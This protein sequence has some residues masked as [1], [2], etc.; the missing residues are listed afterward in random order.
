MVA[1]WLLSI[2]LSR[3][4]VFGGVVCGAVRAGTVLIRWPIFGCV[5]C[6]A[7]KAGTVL[8][9]WSVFGCVVCSAVWAGIGALLPGPDTLTLVKSR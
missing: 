1:Y 6:G 9:R 4:P 7:V 3:W 8:N 5:V 2:V